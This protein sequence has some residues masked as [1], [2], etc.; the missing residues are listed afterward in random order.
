MA[1]RFQIAHILSCTQPAQNSIIIA[2]LNSIPNQ[3]PIFPILLPLT[4][5]QNL[6]NFL[7]F[8][9]LQMI[10]L[11]LFCPLCQMDQRFDQW[12]NAGV[13]KWACFCCYVIYMLGR[14]VP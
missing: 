6:I 8:Y 11:K 7:T 14:A 5:L 10:P 13:I 1:V 9:L 12:V 4:G 2:T 3:R